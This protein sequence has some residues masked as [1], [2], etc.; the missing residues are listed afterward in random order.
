MDYSQEEEI[1]LTIKKMTA[2]FELLDSNNFDLVL[3]K[4]KLR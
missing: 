4:Q 1:F 3:E 2:N